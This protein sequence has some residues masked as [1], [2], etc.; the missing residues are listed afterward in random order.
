MIRDSRSQYAPELAK[1]IDTLSKVQGLGPKSA[2]RAALALLK[3]RDTLMRPL[4]DAILIAAD[5]VKTCDI[6]GNLDAIN[7]CTICQSET[8]DKNVLCVIA[9]VNDLWAFERAGGFKGKYFILGGLLSALD[10]ITP[11][12]LGIPK[13]I[14]HIDNG[15]IKEVVLALAAT[16]D[17][18]STS[19]YL[20]E[21]LANKNLKITRLSHGLPIGGELDNIDEGTLLMALKSRLEV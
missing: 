1:L 15:E 18:L 7:P 20:A 8:R 19:H 9:D 17:G 5:K 16:V 10:G 11:N 12:D 3:K 21:V 6:C 13:L 14:A 4:G 2:R